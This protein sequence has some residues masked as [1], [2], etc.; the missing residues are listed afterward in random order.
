MLRG[1][2]GQVSRVFCIDQAVTEL[3]TFG[4][5]RGAG[6]TGQCWIRTLFDQGLQRDVGFGASW[7]PSPIGLGLG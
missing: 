6:L 1:D 4:P 7:C 3:S 5:I 2:Q